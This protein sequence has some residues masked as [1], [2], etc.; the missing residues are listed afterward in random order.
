MK[1]H[2]S[3]IG[4]VALGQARL[5]ATNPGVRLLDEHDSVAFA[6]STSTLT[7][8]TTHWTGVRVRAREPVQI[9]KL[10]PTRH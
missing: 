1:E 2:G 8:T 6:V 5:Y 7:G 3:L 10:E 9:D 4:H